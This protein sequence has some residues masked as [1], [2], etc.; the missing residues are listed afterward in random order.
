MQKYALI[1]I[2]DKK[3]LEILVSGL[4]RN[5]IKIIAT[6]S[7]HNA[8]KDLGFESIKV[9][10]VA[11]F[12]EMLDGRV[13]TLQPQIH[14]GILADLSKDN[15]LEDLKKYNI[16]PI[17]IVV[18]NLYPFENVLSNYQ[19]KLNDKSLSEKE[20]SNIH[21]DLIEN[22]DIGGVTLI[23]AASKN[24][25]FVSIL[26]DPNDY[27]GYVQALD[28][29]TLNIDYNK[30]LAC[31]GFITT[32]NYDSAIAN[33]FMAYEEIKEQL[34]IS[35]PLKEKLRYGEN[36]FQE[37]AFYE[38]KNKTSYSL[39]T[40]TVLQGKQLSYNNVLDIDS[41]YQAI[42][43]FEEP[44]CIAL[45]HNTPCGIGF[46]ND[47]LNAY[48]D[49]YNTDPISIF[50]GV[51]IFNTEVD[52]KTATK[53][54]EIFLE[55][56]IAPAYTE[57]ALKV[58][59]KKKN[60]RV[61]LGNFN[62][63]NIDFTQ[64]RSVSGG[65]LK[66]AKLDQEVGINVVTSNS[67]GY[68]ETKMLK[69]LYQSVRHVKSNAIVIGQQNLILG[70]CGGMVSRVDSVDV[71]LKK[72]QNHINYNKEIPLMLASDGFF[73]F[74]DIVD[75]CIQYNIKYIIQPGGSINDE[76]LIKACN[77]NGINMIFTGVRYFKH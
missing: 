40:S 38:N 41:A 74:N 50:G 31:K 60:L 65:Y 66:Q 77:E 35:Q 75:Y 47:S 14:G 43:E 23:R 21:A 69:R 6:T 7:T 10:D 11:S 76:K 22:I 37:A 63:E 8:I 59:S 17:S 25:K 26:C 20:L 44:T 48:L 70:I 61:I 3:N 15:H 36:P 57:E 24:N 62:K 42:Y 32:A 13:K 52:E 53:L 33:Y 49:A 30:K 34:L 19:E 68:N 12:P 54:A 55:I 5:N 56:I 39:N 64:I 45:K 1:S 2:S 58:L 72:A 4:I 9:E 18:C 28:N 73:P 51:I 46:A 67:I 71:A 29:Q 27:E 16:N